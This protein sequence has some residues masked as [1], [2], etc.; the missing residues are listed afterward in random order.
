MPPETEAAR[1]RLYPPRPEDLEARLAMDRDPEVMRFIR[2]IP[3]D[4]EAQRA[5][6]RN[7]ILQPP[8]GAYW[9]VEERAAPGFIGWCGLFPLED[10]GLIELGY[11][12]VR[13]AWG[14]GFASEAATTALDHGFQELKLDP[15]VAVSDPDNAASHRVLH[16]IGLRAQGR[17]RHYGQE[18][19]FF[20]LR[21]GE[22][23]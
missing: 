10:S 12:F 2:P 3:E 16:K 9:H 13:A 7:Q 14:R 23:L 6:I 17:A 8:R 18:L 1:L 22:F 20:E 19:A 15:I 4:A 5:E 11:R 21:R